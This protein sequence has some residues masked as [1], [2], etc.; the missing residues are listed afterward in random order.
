MKA[1]QKLDDFFR[2]VNDADFVSGRF[3]VFLDFLVN[4]ERASSTFF[5]NFHRLDAPVFEKF[6]QRQLGDFPPHRVKRRNYQTFRRFV[7]DDFHA[8]QPL[9]RPDVSP[10]PCR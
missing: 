10:P 6:F 9:Q 2:Q 7:Y 1:A 5:F 3:S 4:L 8:R